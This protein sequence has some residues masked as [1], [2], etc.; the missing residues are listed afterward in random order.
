M[1][2]FIFKKQAQ[3]SGTVLTFGIK[4]IAFGIAAGI[5]VGAVAAL[6]A[7][8]IVWATAFRKANPQILYGLPLA[9]V[10]IVYY[11]RLLGAKEP[12]GTNRVI[13]AIRSGER[14]PLVMTPLIIVASVITHLFGGSAGREGAALQ[15]GGSMG[16]ALG[17]LF[18]FPKEDR[19][20]LIMCGMSA[21]FSALFGTPMAA[22]ILAMEISTVGFMYY[23]ALVPCAVAALTARFVAEALGA[24][25]ETMVV[26]NMAKFSPVMGLRTMLFALFASLAA[27]LF[28]VMMHAEKRLFAQYIKNPYLRALFGGLLIVMLTL[29][30]GSQTY[31]GTGSDIIAKC[32]TDPE[33]RMPAYGFFLKIMFTAITLAVGFQG[34]E[35]VPSLFIGATFGNAFGPLFGMSGSLG[36]AIGMACVFSGVT[37]C[38]VASMLICFEMFGFDTA[39]YIMLSVAIAYIFSGN[40]GIYAAQ[41]IHFDKYRAGISDISAH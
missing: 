31:N 8:A 23:S 1:G 17:R 35:I 25:A 38:P 14:V 7:R 34:G 15:V 16:N 26:Q 24:E 33:F 28:V 6:F 5:V 18:R 22:T 11:Y 19:P 10:F 39:P 2:D 37:N 32:V 9:G 21:S 29:L 40:F 27:I 13:T 30:V 3:D 12:K 20:I 36:A 41:K 4:W